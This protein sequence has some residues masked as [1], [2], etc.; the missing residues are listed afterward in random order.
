MS[1]AAV[2]TYDLEEHDDPAPEPA[3]WNTFTRL[4]VKALLASITDVQQ[5]LAEFRAAGGLAAHRG[6]ATPVQLAGIDRR[7][8]SIR[9]H[10]EAILNDPA[11]CG[12]FGRHDGRYRR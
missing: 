10:A 5:R 8:E 4:Q 9:G 2:W 12:A 1:T 7:L 6:H 3:C 11:W